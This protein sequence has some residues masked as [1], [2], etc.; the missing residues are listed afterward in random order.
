[1]GFYRRARETTLKDLIKKSLFSVLVGIL[2]FVFIE[3]ASSCLILAH[4]VASFIL[5]NHSLDRQYFRYD[6]ELGWV[7]TPNF[8]DKDC[9]GPGVFLKT[10][11]RGFRG[12]E[13]ITDKIPPGKVRL[14]CSGDSFTMGV[15]VDND[16]V[17]CQELASMNNALDTV[18]MAQA[19]Y[20]VDQMYLSYRRDGISVQHDIQ[21]LAVIGDDFRRMHLT[22]MYGYA[23]PILKL[24]NGGL[25]VAN[26]PVPRYVR[27]WVPALHLVK[28]LRSV[29]LAQTLLKKISPARPPSQPDPAFQQIVSL[30]IDDLHS[31]NNRKDSILVLVYLPTEGDYDGTDD[32]LP[33]W[34]TLMHQ[35][36]AREGLQLI[37]LTDDFQKL[38]PQEVRRFFISTNSNTVPFASGH[39][40]N[41]GHD[42]VAKKI[43]SYLFSRPEIQ[44]KFAERVQVAATPGSP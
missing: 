16:H 8:Y 29:Q 24:Q 28:D 23:K 5:S 13:E 40:S 10:N 34:R 6:S 32:S 2:C 33:Q 39:Y 12:N 9:F 31:I 11:S 42:F 3:G 19:A 15:G 44:K 25:V 17:W 4:T 27:R 20:G 14:L 41:E 38:P 22:E 43:Y 18:N 21:I 35:E 26:V 36:A 30:L 37:D 7:A 1:L